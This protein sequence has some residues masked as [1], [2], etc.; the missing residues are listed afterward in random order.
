MQVYDI[1]DEGMKLECDIDESGFHALAITTAALLQA[2]YP[3]GA[4]VCRRSGDTSDIRSFDF[5]SVG[6][7]YLAE[8]VLNGTWRLL[9]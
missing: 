9:D 8:N 7:A 6:G 4:R 5:G 1:R 3:N 2:Q